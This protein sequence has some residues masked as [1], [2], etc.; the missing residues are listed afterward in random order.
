MF[1]SMKPLCEDIS[2]QNKAAFTLRVILAAYLIVRSPEFI[3]S[4]KT[5]GF[6]PWQTLSNSSPSLMFGMV[7]TI[8]QNSEKYF[9][10]EVL[11]I[12]RRSFSLEFCTLSKG[13]NSWYTAASNFVQVVGTVLEPT[14]VYHGAA[15]VIENNVAAKD[16]WIC[17]SKL[18][19]FPSCTK[20]KYC[21]I[22]KNHVRRV[23]SSRLSSKV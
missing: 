4:R 23:Y 3:T 5:L 2:G 14:G 22:W 12:S 20:V 19:S 10:T 9:E 16:I 13:T 15:A 1:E 7:K 8:F 18:S 6:S 21:L 17:S 11:C